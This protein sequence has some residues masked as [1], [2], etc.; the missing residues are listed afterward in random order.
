MFA[1]FDASAQ[2]GRVPFLQ[3]SF[4]QSAVLVFAC[5]CGNASDF[6]E[7]DKRGSTTYTFATL[8][9]GV[10]CIFIRVGGQDLCM[11]VVVIH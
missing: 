9:T 1:M 4:Q 7:K 3:S 8:S 2:S 6:R 5:M 11:R 10:Y